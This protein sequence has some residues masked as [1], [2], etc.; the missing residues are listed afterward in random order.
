MENKTIKVLVSDDPDEPFKSEPWLSLIGECVDVSCKTIDVGNDECYLYKDRWAVPVRLCEIVSDL[1]PSISLEEAMEAF[2]NGKQIRH[3]T[4]MEG[5][6]YRL[7]G[8]TVYCNEGTP[9]MELEHFKMCFKQDEFKIGWYIVSDSSEST[10]DV[11]FTASD[12][13]DSIYPVPPIEEG[14]DH[15]DRIFKMQDNLN[16]LA[17]LESY[18]KTG[19]PSPMEIAESVYSVDFYSPRP[20]AYAI[21]IE[22]SEFASKIEKMQPADQYKEEQYVP[23]VGNMVQTISESAKELATKVI[24]HFCHGVPNGLGGATTESI[25]SVGSIIDFFLNDE[26]KSE[27]QEF[28]LWMRQ[29][30][31]LAGEDRY[32]YN[33]EYYTYDAVYMI[34]KNRGK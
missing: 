6:S 5:L 16:L 2:T 9:Y 8:D 3:E 4:F 21:K 1:Q 25:M 19:I 34:F 20:S 10:E 23:E 11:I 29:N 28:H 32:L 22:R 15:M 14:I 7:N 26:L 31:F 27:A 24:D 13:A 18:L 12:L 33:K 17:K 30:A